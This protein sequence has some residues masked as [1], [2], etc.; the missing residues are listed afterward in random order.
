MQNWPGSEISTNFNCPLCGLVRP[1]ILQIYAPLDNSQ[2]HRTFYVFAC[3]NSICSNQSK[4]WQCIRVEHLEKIVERHTSA[5]RKKAQNTNSTINNKN[6]TTTTKTTT[7]W[8]SGA[9]DWGGDEFGGG[10]GGGGGGGIGFGIDGGAGDDDDTFDTN[11]KFS[12]N[13]HLMMMNQQQQQQLQQPP[14][15]LDDNLNEQN[16]NT[17]VL[18]NNMAISTKIENR[19]HQSDDE[20][21]SNSM[22]DPIPMFNNLQVIDERNANCGEQQGELVAVFALL[23]RKSNV[24]S[25]SISFH[26]N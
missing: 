22:D 26:S 11:T 25:H 20:D 21:E 8:C 16:G 2:F 12:S 1:L 5:H 9:D 19:N 14:P 6:I 13:Q 4:G 7:N 10:V 24:N 15:S 3:M 18:C 17:M 23:A